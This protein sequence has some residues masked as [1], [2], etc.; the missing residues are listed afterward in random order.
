M[1]G[2]THRSNSISSL[3]FQQKNY[4]TSPLTTPT[5]TS[6]SI[7][8]P[9]PAPLP[10]PN[11]NALTHRSQAHRVNSNTSS[12]AR[13]ARTC[14]SIVTTSDGWDIWTAS[15]GWMVIGRRHRN[16]KRR[17]RPREGVICQICGAGRWR[18]CGCRSTYI[19]FCF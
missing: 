16:R 18:T 3:S 17:Y 4:L 7:L 8:S 13:S 1:P 11:A 19:G 10:V 14:S 12:S 15:I 6:A 2:I 9:S 5:V